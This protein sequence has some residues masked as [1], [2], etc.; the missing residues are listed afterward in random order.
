MKLLTQTSLYM[1]TLSLCLFFA[2][3]VAFY[4][5]FRTFT[6]QALDKDL[7]QE[8]QEVVLN[9]D[10]FLQAVEDGNPFFDRMEF[11]PVNEYISKEIAYYDSI[12]QPE[13]QLK[14]VPVRFVRF[15]SKVDNQAY[16]VKIFKSKI[17]YIKVN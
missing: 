12:V 1:V 8:R 11:F 3:G 15:Y 14:P 2:C 16:E 13:K 5:V 7:D 9:M 10:V 4:F 6:N 17:S